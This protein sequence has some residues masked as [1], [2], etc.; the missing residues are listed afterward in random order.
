MA[1]GMALSEETRVRTGTEG[2]ER[3]RRFTTTLYELLAVLQ[4]L[5]G[6]DDDA[7]VVATAV[8]LLRGRPS[9]SDRRVS[10]L[11]T[12]AGHPSIAVQMACQSP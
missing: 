8:H 2:E 5:V 1:T 4:E 7:L 11:C 12:S 6:P 10:S 9:P 3:P